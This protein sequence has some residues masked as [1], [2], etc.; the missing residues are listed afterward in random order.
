MINHRGNEIV[1]VESLK[2]YL[3][4]EFRPCEVV[5]QN[6]VAEVPPYPYVSYT[7]TTPVSA[8]GG[9]YSVAEDGR[10]YKKIEQ[11]WSFMVQSDDQDEALN[12]ALEM[13]D[14]FA[15]T[16]LTKLADNG[17]VVDRLRD[18]TTR[19]SMITIQYEYR[20]GLDVTFGL[21]H[22]ITNEGR[23][24][25]DVIETMKLGDASTEKALTPDELSELLA[26]RLDGE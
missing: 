22:E 12:L 26:K 13:Y 3:S 1:I 7:V 19:D 9:T 11:T 17:I 5:R 18:V 23:N 15:L 8:R 6:Q 24:T 10:R 20:C 2:D 25:F 14:F 16:G 4:T 21:L